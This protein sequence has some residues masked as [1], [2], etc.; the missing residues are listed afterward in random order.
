MRKGLHPGYIDRK[1]EIAIANR[2]RGEGLGVLNDGVMARNQRLAVNRGTGE[3]YTDD[4]K[5]KK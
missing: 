3:R 4:E 5:S 2:Q 1:R